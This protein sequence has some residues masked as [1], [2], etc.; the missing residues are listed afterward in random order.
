MRPAAARRTLTPLP[1]AVHHVQCQRVQVDRTPDGG[2]IIFARVFSGGREH[3][4]ECRLAKHIYA[5]LEYACLQQY[6]G[7]PQHR[8]R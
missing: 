7:R 3:L 5:D 6:M 8:K 1:V 4:L 2:A